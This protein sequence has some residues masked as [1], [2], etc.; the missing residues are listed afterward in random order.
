MTTRMIPRETIDVLR[1][2][3]DISLSAIGMDCILYIPTNTSFVEAEKKDIYAVPEDYTYTSYSAKIFVE[4][5][6]NVWKLKRLGL[7]TEDQ[8]PILCRFGSKAIA[9]EGSEAGTEVPIDVCVK[10]YFRIEPEFIP[11][12]YKGIE[13]FVVVNVAARSMQDSLIRR[14]YSAVP[15]RVEV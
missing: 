10:S 3:V 6:P 15:R 14:I 7:F 12:N 1:D 2:Y 13:E 4:W 8:L 11:D 5:S 9:L